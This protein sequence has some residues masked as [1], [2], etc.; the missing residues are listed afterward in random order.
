MEKMAG[1][2]C[3]TYD[4]KDLI[5]PRHDRSKFVD[6]LDNRSRKLY[7]RRLRGKEFER[8]DWFAQSLGLGE[9]VFDMH[10]GG[11]GEIRRGY[12]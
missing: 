1:N 2:G 4:R 8:E 6:F 3:E 7:L 5:H 9:L 10:R 11:G 12:S